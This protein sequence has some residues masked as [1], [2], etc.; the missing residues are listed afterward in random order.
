MGLIICDKHGGQGFY[1]VCEHLH[2]DLENGVYPEMKELPLLRVKI[3]DDCYQRIGA[4]E[5]PCISFDECIN[6]VDS[7]SEEVEEL[8]SAKYKQINRFAICR[9]CDLEIQLIWARRKG[10]KAPFEAFENTLTFTE[11]QT[12]DNLEKFLLEKFEFEQS[13]IVPDHKA[14]FISA[15]HINQ[16]LTIEI[17]YVTEL[18]KLNIL[19][20]LI[21]E[22]FKDQNRNQRKI[23]FYERENWIEKK[24]PGGY[25]INSRGQEKIIQ[26][27]LI[28]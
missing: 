19:I 24:S 26:E 9:I 16:A 18:D 8:A 10:I 5:L 14:L 28:K 15:G 27:I 1:E 17:Y 7:I 20:N 2:S 4:N 13:V 23:R 12:I 11:K 22:F 25:K 21:E 6:N 3:C